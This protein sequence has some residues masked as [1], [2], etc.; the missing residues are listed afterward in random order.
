MVG[1]DAGTRAVH[2]H[3]DDFFVLGKLVVAGGMGGQPVSERY[4]LIQWP[5]LRPSGDKV[6]FELLVELL[7]GL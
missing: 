5:G 1:G 2:V 7:G 6:L 3:A 4:L